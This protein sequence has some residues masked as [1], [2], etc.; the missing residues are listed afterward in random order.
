MKVVLPEVQH[1]AHTTEEEEEGCLS[2]W[3]QELA[4]PLFFCLT[5]RKNKQ[6]LLALLKNLK[7]G[8]GSLHL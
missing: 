4:A 6:W 7:R 8:F 1:G 3:R 5:Q 2:L